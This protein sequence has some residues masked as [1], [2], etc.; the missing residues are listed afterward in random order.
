MNFDGQIKLAITLGDMAGIGPEVVLKALPAIAEN[1]VEITLVG[2]QQLLCERSQQLNL[3]LENYDILDVPLG[4]DQTIQICAI[5]CSRTESPA[6]RFI[7][8]A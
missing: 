8:R 1:R 7:L 4:T 6:S 2:N 5:I 3:P